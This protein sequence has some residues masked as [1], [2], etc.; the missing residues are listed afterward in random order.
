MNSMKEERERDEQSRPGLWRT[1]AEP[2]VSADAR[3]IEGYDLSSRAS[4]SQPT[5]T[6]IAMIQAF[7]QASL[8]IAA[9][10]LYSINTI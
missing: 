4:A 7:L 3:N 2:C 5:L 9:S 10:K 8:R 1:V 6:I